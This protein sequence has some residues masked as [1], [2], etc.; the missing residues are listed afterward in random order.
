MGKTIIV[1]NRLPVNVK[2][3]TEG[4]IT[5]RSSAG[6]LATGLSSVYQQDGNVWVGWPGA[7][8]R[9]TAEKKQAEDDLRAEHMRP[10]FLTTSEIKDYYEG[11]S[12][13]TL[14]P[15]F[16]YFNEYTISAKPTGNAT[17]K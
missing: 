5:Y 17:K 15:T 14:W 16:H 10:V 11:F 1:S 2:R 3:D 6:G 8:F 12:N 9:T 4:A 13:E 7:Y